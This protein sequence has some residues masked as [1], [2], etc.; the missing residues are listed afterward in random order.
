M[1]VRTNKGELLQIVNKKASE[2][3]EEVDKI[4]LMG[5]KKGTKKY[6]IVKAM[7][8][9][10]QEREILIEQVRRYEYE[11]GLMIGASLNIESYHTII[12]GGKIL[13]AK[14]GEIIVDTTINEDGVIVK[15]P[16]WAV[17]TIPVIF[18]VEPDVES[19]TIRKITI[20]KRDGSNM[21]LFHINSSNCCLGKNAH[22]DEEINKEVLDKEIEDLKAIMKTI[23]YHSTY[24]VSDDFIHIKNYT[25]YKY[26]YIP[27]R[28]DRIKVLKETGEDT[29]SE[30]KELESYIKSLEGFEQAH[31]VKCSYIKDEFKRSKEEENVEVGKQNNM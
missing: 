6:G 16:E 22:T 9:M 14:K 28:E 4:T 23:N 30:E 8:D 21:Q 26:T 10:I 24:G 18:R 29:E 20:S 3:T 5:L 25:K 19:K 17:M 13:L 27:S 11:K 7:K 2:I 1:I 31:R 15:L 12:E